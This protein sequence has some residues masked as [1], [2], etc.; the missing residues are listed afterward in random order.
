MVR[1]VESKT[2]PSADWLKGLLARRHT[3]V[4][5]VAQANKTARIAWALLA[6]GT[7]FRPDYTPDVTVA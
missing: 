6:H 3:N 5:V 2:D 1:V 4:A 7:K